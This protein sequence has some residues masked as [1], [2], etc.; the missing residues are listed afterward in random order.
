[1]RYKEVEFEVSST[2]FLVVARF[3]LRVTTGY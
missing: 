1:S 2:C 3:C